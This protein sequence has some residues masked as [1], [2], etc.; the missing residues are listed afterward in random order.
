MSDPV[1]QRDLHGVAVRVRTTTQSTRVLLRAT[2]F[3]HAAPQDRAAVDVRLLRGDPSPDRTVTDGLALSTGLFWAPNALWYRRDRFAVS[4]ERT[5]D[6]LRV[7]SRFVPRIDRRIRAAVLARGT[8]A[9]ED[10]FAEVRE[11]VLLPWMWLHAAV[12][13]TL[14]LHGAAVAGSE[15]SVVLLGLNGAGK[16]TLAEKLCEQR[17]QLLADNTV[18]ISPAQTVLRMAELARSAVPPRQA[19][20]HFRAF[21]KW[22]YSPDLHAPTVDRAPLRLCVVLARKPNRTVVTPLHLDEAVSRICAMQELVPEFIEGSPLG[23][24]SDNSPWDSR[25][26]ARTLPERVRTALRGVPTIELS[27]RAED[28]VPEQI[29]EALGGG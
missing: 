20:R 9:F 25:W 10:S 11:A 26:S 2:G 6:E 21:G 3:S 24:L 14:F 13:G 1:L 7:E 17:G 23:L 29:L 18:A 15:G 16:S 8:T 27:I 22:F 28:P 12:Y 19:V 4:V 5:G